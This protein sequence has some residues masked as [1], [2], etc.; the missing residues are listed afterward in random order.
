MI[1]WP[2]GKEFIVN[3]DRFLTVV[4]KTVRRNLDISSYLMCFFQY[5]LFWKLQLKNWIF[6]SMWYPLDHQWHHLAITQPFFCMLLK[7]GIKQLWKKFYYHTF[8][9]QNINKNCLAWAVWEQTSSVSPL[10]WFSDY[11]AH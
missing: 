3:Y 9:V 2:G 7:L 11:Q 8:N 6:V 4:K 1:I 5:W 10:Q